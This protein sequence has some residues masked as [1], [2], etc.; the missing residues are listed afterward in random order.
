MPKRVMIKRTLFVL[1]ATPLLLLGVSQ[2]VKAL[3]QLISV[4][5]R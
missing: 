1:F 5:L 4:L 2:S 3:S